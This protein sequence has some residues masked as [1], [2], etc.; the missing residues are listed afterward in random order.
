M[1]L[2]WP[3]ILRGT[4]KRAAGLYNPSQACYANATLQ[5]LFHTPPFLRIASAHQSQS[6]ENKGWCMLCAL[7]TTGDEHW[8]RQ[9]SYMPKE[10]HNHLSQIHKGF[11]KHKQ[12][13]AHE[14]FR[15]VTDALQATALAGRPKDLPAKIKNS[16]WVYKLWGGQVRSRVICDR[17]STPSDTFDTFLDLSLDVPPN[18]KPS[19]LSMLREFCKDDKLEGE[20]KYNCENCKRKADAKKSFRISHAPPVLTLH[21]KRF[22][23]R[24]NSFGNKANAEKYSGFIEFGEWL[25][26]ANFMSEGT[27]YRLFGVTCHRG[28]ELRFGH[29]TSYV[30]GPSGQWYH[31]DDEDMSAVRQDEVLR[32]K[33]A[34]LLSYIR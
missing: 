14:F 9:G 31:A 6:C 21:L 2:S 19:V 12:E 25:D 33:Q 10:V 8:S 18:R 3:E 23:V 5:V 20:N 4:K 27:K 7:R 22:N 30:R 29:Y 17:C 11:N 16:T 1:D 15:F 32:D 24:Y 26:I 28:A 34:Y 13:D